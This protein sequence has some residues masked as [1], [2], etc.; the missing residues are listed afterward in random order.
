MRVYCLDL[1]IRRNTLLLLHVLKDLRG[2]LF[3]MLCSV[4]RRIFLKIYVIILLTFSDSK[5]NLCVLFY[6][7]FYVTVFIYLASAVKRNKRMW[8]VEIEYRP[9]WLGF[10]RCVFTCVGW[11]VT[12]C[13]PIWQ[14]TLHSSEMEFYTLPLPFYL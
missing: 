6:F 10:R 1:E 11:Q 9:V 3:Y 2:L 13:D 7:E 12:L 8:N 4:F 14:V 5:C